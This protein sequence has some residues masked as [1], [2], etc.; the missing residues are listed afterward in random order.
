MDQQIKENKFLEF[1]EHNENLYGTHLDS[2]RDVIKQGNWIDAVIMK[3]FLQKFL[4]RKNV[5]FGLRSKCTEDATQ[6][7]WVHAIRNLC[8]C[9]R[10]G[11]T[12][13]DLRRASCDWRFAKK[14]SGTFWIFLE[15]I[16]F[17]NSFFKTNSIT[18]IVWSVPNYFVFVLHGLW[19]LTDKA[20][21]D[22]AQG[23]PEP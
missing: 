9:T 3:L 17:S 12:E 20:Q 18:V 2:I 21:S 19:S 11:A 8:W 5:C 7:H 14:L 1:G 23:E 4:H 10:N 13:T 16:S 6:Q 22:I 15:L